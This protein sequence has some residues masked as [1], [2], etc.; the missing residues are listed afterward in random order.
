MSRT[1]QKVGR[2]VLVAVLCCAACGDPELSGDS[3]TL[4][5]HQQP[6]AS[7]QFDCDAIAYGIA[8]VPEAQLR[9]HVPAGYTLLSDGSGNAELDLAFGR[10]ATSSVNGVP[11]G[12]IDF[13]AGFAVLVPPAWLEVAPGTAVVYQ[14]WY[15]TQ[16]KPWPKALTAAGM[17]RVVSKPRE[18]ALAFPP[19]GDAS[20]NVTLRRGSYGFAA[21]VPPTQLITIPSSTVIL[22]DGPRGTARITKSCTLDLNPAFG[23]LS[24]HADPHTILGSIATSLNAMVAD[25]RNASC[26]EQLELRR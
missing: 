11:S 14:L 15:D 21:N 24:A 2:G 6:L 10:C 13:A 12:P 17:G 26:T 18:L 25:L 22:Y 20:G 5:L 7:L 8:F 3:R 19:A 16:N 9:A 23:S 1:G 4:A